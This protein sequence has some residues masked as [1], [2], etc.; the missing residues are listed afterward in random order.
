MDKQSLFYGIGKLWN[1]KIGEMGNRNMDQRKEKPEVLAP[2]GS[3]ASLKAA[4]HAGCDAVYM[5]GS[6][7]GARAYADNPDE[8]ELLHAIEYCHLHGVK[9]YMT[10]NTLLKDSELQTELYSYLLPYY[11]AGLDAVIVQDMGVLHMLH[12]C[13]PDLPLHASTQMSLTMGR[14]LGR[15]REYG[16]TRIVPARELSLQELQQMRRCTDMEIEVFV[17]GALCYCYSGKCLFS[18][19]QGG[20]SGNRGRCAGPCRMRYQ[21]PGRPGYYLSPKELCNL[22]YLTELIA[23]GV[24]SFKIE[25]RM[26]QP[27]YT[28]FVTSI[29]RKYVDLCYEMSVEEFQEWKC[30]HDREWQEDLRKLAE[31]YNRAGFTQGYLE[32][33]AGS[34]QKKKLWSGNMLSMKRPRH[35]GVKIGTVV[36][37]DA[38]IAEYRLEKDL[39]PQDVV[40]FRDAKEQTNYEYTSGKSGKAGEMIRARYQKGC[41]IRSGDGVYRTRH[42]RLLDEI[43]EKYSGEKKL[44][45]DGSFV[46]K[47]GERCHL[48]LK[49]GEYQISVSGDEVCPAEKQ[50]A[51]EASV[52][53]VL[54]QTGDS[55]F[56]F[57][58]LAV[59]VQENIFLPVGMLKKLR[60]SALQELEMQIVSRSYRR[61]P[62]EPEQLSADERR[63]NGG[64]PYISI[65]VTNMEQLRT[66]LDFS[67]P[68]EIIIR[69]DGME[70]LPATEGI[71][72]VQNS[73]K[74]AVIAMPIIWR[75]A[76]WQ[77]YER[78]YAKGRGIFA[79][80]QPDAYL[81][82]NMESLA[83]LQ[84][85]LKVD[86]DKI[87][88]DADLYTMNEE[89]Y[90][91]WQE[92]GVRKMT[93]PWELT[94]EECSRLAFRQH[95]QYIV[96]GHI[97]LMVSAQCLT[98]NLS[99]CAAN[100]AK[101]RNQALSF[102]D[103]SGRTFFAVN[104]CKYCYNVIY[105][106]KPYN[107]TDQKEKI[108]SWGFGALRY[109]FTLETEQQVREILSGRMTGEY[110]RGHWEQVI[111]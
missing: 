67:E 68:S 106:G 36:S 48:T 66:V 1:R 42:Q 50:A 54:S 51:T 91:W 109:E 20:R 59:R 6:H 35:G 94:G 81:I 61:K 27:E 87:I 22:P 105:Q 21:G 10:V 4:V 25:G 62:E 34:P 85:I 41:R 107:V 53:R 74:R 104:Y 44:E 76:F 31:L 77:Q 2:A 17:H 33:Q 95:L 96:Y 43:R 23:A 12:R 24:N 32:G 110:E 90:R 71:R 99:R 83:F 55:S 39:L 100:S 9:L 7:F 65:S 84:D 8:N 72:L 52:R 15:L 98:S 78:E 47:A 11:Q 86:S 46:A 102:R 40:E 64:K 88:A 45:I 5:G 49:R 75:E 63:Q 60:R 29:Y 73:G 13:F 80:I 38:K 58:D 97:P 37:V 56:V 111:Q 57:R 3:V 19:M 69:M 103:E 92:Q 30:R 18:S 26:K 108:E 101:K 28:A 16:V 14:G 93:A 79:E 70:D 89:A 82:H